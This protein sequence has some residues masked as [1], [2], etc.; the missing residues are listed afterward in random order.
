MLVA[1]WEDVPEFLR[2]EGPVRYLTNIFHN[3][4]RIIIH[5]DIISINYRI[6]MIKKYSENEVLC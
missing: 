3:S 2:E 4:S 6:G 5:I 1:T